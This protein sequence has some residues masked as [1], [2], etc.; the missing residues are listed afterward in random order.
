[1]ILLFISIWI[2]CTTLWK[3]LPVAIGV[4]G[5]PEITQLTPTATLQA[6][7]EVPGFMIRKEGRETTVLCASTVE[8]FISCLSL[9]GPRFIRSLLGI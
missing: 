5:R 2:L 6:Y 8:P 1:M 9:S 3:P 7:C 4:L